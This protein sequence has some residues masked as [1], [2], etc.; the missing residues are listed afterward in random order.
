MSLPNSVKAH[1]INYGGCM[2]ATTLNGKIEMLPLYKQQ[3]V[4]NFVDFLLFSPHNVPTKNDYPERQ[5][6]YAGCMKGAF[7]EMSD[8]FNE[9]LEVFKDYM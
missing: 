5:H 2:T 9:P 6:P 8:D 7:G 3:E 4:S 1:I